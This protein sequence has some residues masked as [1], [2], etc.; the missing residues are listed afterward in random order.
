MKQ[1]PIIDLFV[2]VDYNEEPPLLAEW[3]MFEN[4]W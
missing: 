2:A 1:F 4:A 3:Q